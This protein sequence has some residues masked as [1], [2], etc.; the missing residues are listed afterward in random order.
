MVG[1]C[2]RG[3]IMEILL[4]MQLGVSLFHTEY[5]FT[6]ANQYKAF[7][8]KTSLSD[9]DFKEIEAEEAIQEEVSFFSSTESHLDLTD[10]IH[11]NSFVPV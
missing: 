6:Q 7:H 4:G 9:Q 8:F 2:T 10:E 1:L 3:T 11:K 5:P